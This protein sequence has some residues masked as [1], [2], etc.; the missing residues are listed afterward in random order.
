V[1]R[2]KFDLRWKVAL[3][4]PLDYSGFDPS[5][6][7]TFA[8]VSSTTSKSATPSTG[9][10]PW[11]TSRLHSRPG[12]P[13][14]RH[15]QRQGAGAGAGHLH[16]AAQRDAQAA[17]GGASTAA[18]TRALSSDAPAAACY[19]DQTARRT[20]TG[21]TPNSCC[22]TPGAFDDA[23]AVLELAAEHIDDDE[24]RSLG[25]LLTK[26]LATMWSQYQVQAHLG[27]GTA[28]DR[29]I[30]LTDPDAPWTQEPGASVQRLKVSVPPTSTAR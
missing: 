23:E 12:H 18:A 25:W 15:D 9:S 16:P 21:R 19:L 7:P 27:Q 5:A 1:D 11:A 6:S 20:S 17:Q 2:L 22:P 3:N 4:L 26:I 30:S 10:S 28:T 29:I 13:A 24:V 14:H 8:S